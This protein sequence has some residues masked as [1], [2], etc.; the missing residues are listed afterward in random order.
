[1]TKAAPQLRMVVT[2][3]EMKA[4]PAQPTLPAP[5]RTALLRAEQPTL[6]FYRY[7]YNTI[8]ERWLW[9][10]RRAMD[11]AALASIIHDPGTEIY[12]LYSGG[13][14]AGY[15]ELN[16]RAKKEIELA[17]FGLMPEFIGQGLGRYFLSWAVNCAWAYEPERLWVSTNNFDHPRA[18]QSYQRAGFAPYHQ[19][20]L[21]FDDPRASG[22]IPS[23]VPVP[24]SALI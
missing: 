14:P 8:G 19:E 17:Y 7:L 16:R 20:V 22:L 18:L 4:R 15:A 3:L 2:H 13:V 12:V 24:E 23:H 9:Y 6:S 1:M 21:I 10:E 5:R 11:D